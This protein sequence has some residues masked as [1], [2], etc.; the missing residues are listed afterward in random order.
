MGAF[1]RRF[2]SRRRSGTGESGRTAMELKDIITFG[3]HEPDTIR[4]IERSARHEA[5]A[6]ATLCADGH[7]GYAVPIGG[8]IAYE[9]H[10]SPSGVGFD[11]ACGNKAVLTDADSTEV[12]ASI[13]TIMNDVWKT[14]SFGIGLNNK[15]ERV[16][17]EL[18]DDA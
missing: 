11:I 14:L 10:I 3:L 17:H 12:K 18:Y 16:D 6:G 4:Q 9:G 1:C 13:K 7:K 2:R 8:V 15:D 5:V